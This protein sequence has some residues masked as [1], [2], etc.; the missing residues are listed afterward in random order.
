[1]IK[2]SFTKNFLRGVFNM[3]VKKTIASIAAIAMVASATSLAPLFTGT[4]ISAEENDDT[5]VAAADDEVEGGEEE[6]GEE[7]G[8]GDG[9]GD[10]SS[11]GEDDDEPVTTPTLTLGGSG[12]VDSVTGGSGSVAVSGTTVTVTLTPADDGTIAGQPENGTEG[13]RQNYHV[14][15]PVT[16]LSSDWVFADNS[17]YQFDSNDNR[18]W[19]ITS[20]SLKLWL[21]VESGS[22]TVVLKNSKTN[23]TFSITVTTVNGSTVVVTPEEPEEPAVTEPTDAEKAAQAFANLESGYFTWGFDWVDVND[24]NHLNTIT[25]QLNTYADVE[26]AEVSLVNYTAGENGMVTFTIKVKVG[27]EEVTRD[28][29]LQCKAPEAP[30]VPD[31][32]VTIPDPIIY[33]PGTGA[34]VSV[35]SEAISNAVSSSAQITASRKADITVNAAETDVTPQ[36]VEA[37]VKN[38]NSKTLTLQY[39]SALKVSVNK[40]DI[41]DADANLD[42]SV[43]GEKFLSSKTVKNNKTLKN[44][45]KI[46]QIDFVNKGDLEGVDKVTIKSKAGIGYAGKTVTIYEYVNGKLVKAGVAKV[47][48]AGLVK[49]DTDHLGQFVI[50]VQ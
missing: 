23:A 16:N 7:D 48:G 19:N 31:T 9:N 13:A 42:F 37:F 14:V 8:D 44:A 3:N 40:S 34:S 26:G 28:V 46:I 41:N 27:D 20:G 21:P 15:I 12:T 50:A 38:K 47:N 24:Q 43:S 6:G 36:M 32:P 35:S 5:V 39:S 10:G 17:Q 45:S 4:S 33:V 30:V 18:D 25:E 22:C 1:M 29:T 2:K 11:D 49:F